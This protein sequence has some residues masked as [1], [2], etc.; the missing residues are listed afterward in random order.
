MQ[1][2][3]VKHVNRSS[4]LLSTWGQEVEREY[5]R[6]RKAGYKE[7]RYSLKDSS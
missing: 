5:S 4:R 1:G 7:T 2:Y 3:V 6:G